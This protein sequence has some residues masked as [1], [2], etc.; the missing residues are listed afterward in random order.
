MET[1]LVGEARKR[2]LFEISARNR[3]ENYTRITSHN[4]V[5]GLMLSRAMFWWPFAG[6]LSWRV[7]FHPWPHNKIFV[8]NKVTLGQFL[9]R[10]FDFV[11]RIPLIFYNRI[12]VPPPPSPPPPPS[13]SSSSIG[14]T[15][16]CVLWPVEKCSSIFSYLPPTFSIFSL[17]ALED[18][19]LLPHSIFSWVFPFF[20]SLPVLQ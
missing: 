9:H 16:H 19:F 13:T 4:T 15:A 3:L 1:Q 6:L 20:S 18:L 14:T 8:V 2:N 11:S 5:L 7:E 17:P 10:F 12:H